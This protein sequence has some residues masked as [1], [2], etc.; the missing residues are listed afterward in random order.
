MVQMNANSLDAARSIADLQL[1]REPK[2][3]AMRV[4][5]AVAPVRY[6]LYVGVVGVPHTKEMKIPFVDGERISLKH[7]TVWFARKR[8]ACSP[9]SLDISQDMERT[10]LR[11]VR[12]G[13]MSRCVGG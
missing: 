12:P 11:I 10:L 4:M 5:V 1:A 8:Y 13:E 6:G 9:R 2:H 7:R 3:P